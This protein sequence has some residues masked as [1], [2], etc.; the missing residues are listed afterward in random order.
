MGEDWIDQRYESNKKRTVFVV[1]PCSTYERVMLYHEFFSPEAKTRY[2][3]RQGGFGHGR[4]YGELEGED[5]VAHV[6]FDEIDGSVV[7]FVETGPVMHYR[8]LEE[9]IVTEFQH[10]PKWD[11]GLRTPVTNPMNF[12]HCLD[13]IRD[14]RRGK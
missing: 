4:K 7:A 12:S 6:H 13:A 10:V 3:Y 8:K 9:W 2:P 1:W 5:L 14:I 11:R